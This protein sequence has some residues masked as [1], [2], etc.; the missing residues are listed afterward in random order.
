VSVYEQIARERAAGGSLREQ[1]LRRIR[2]LGG[3]ADLKRRENR[4][5]FSEVL[6]GFTPSGYQLEVN[7]HLASFVTESQGCSVELHASLIDESRRVAQFVRCL[8]LTPRL[9]EH[10]L[11]R[12]E[13]GYRGC[14]IG[15]MCLK[16]A[17]ELYH[18]LEI[19]RIRLLAGLQTGTW[20]WA[21]CG[22]RFI[23]P[24]QRDKMQ[25]WAREVCDA[26]GVILDASALSDPIQFALI[27]EPVTFAEL[28]TELPTYAAKF[29][30]AAVENKIALNEEIDLGKAVLLTGPCWD[31]ELRL[32]T[33]DEIL[34]EH[35]AS[36]KLQGR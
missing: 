11:F 9:A 10:R 12:L 2:L 28:I 14:G 3:D 13:E 1:V 30:T 34:F 5:A 31:G 29:E 36:A 23:N 15:V 7:L 25:A 24:D 27:E 16:R 20:Y 4:E 32:G 35:F 17:I 18:D 33:E 19:D 22:F 8:F 21:Q 6:A 26:V